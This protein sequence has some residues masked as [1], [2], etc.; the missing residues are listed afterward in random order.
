MSAFQETVSDFL[1]YLQGAKSHN[2]VKAYQRALGDFTSWYTSTVQESFSLGDVAAIDVREY[3]RYLLNRKISPATINQHLAALKALFRWAR[4]KGL[5]ASNPTEV[6]NGVK[7]AKL[8]PKWLDKTEERKLLRA[9]PRAG[10]AR[11]DLGPKWFLMSR[12]TTATRR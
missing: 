2:T 1:D 11:N 10:N 4:R 6:F 12:P 8:A 7:K 9:A 3:Q 5:A